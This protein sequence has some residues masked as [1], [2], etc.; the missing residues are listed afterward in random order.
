MVSDERMSTIYGV[1]A[2]PLPIFTPYR[3]GVWWDKVHEYVH[4]GVLD[5][6]TMSGP[7]FAVV[8]A[9]KYVAA[10]VTDHI[11][12]PRLSQVLDLYPM[13]PLVDRIPFTVLSLEVP[14]SHMER[15]I[16]P[17]SALGALCLRLWK[18]CSLGRMTDLHRYTHGIS[19]DSYQTHFLIGALLTRLPLTEETARVVQWF[20]CRA[21]LSRLPKTLQAAIF[22]T[23][24]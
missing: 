24:A 16:R 9:A 1:A 5:V 22:H 3:V 2:E 6:E 19:L 17:S 14:E 10:H 8:R 18:A 21:P 11:I 12:L 4:S 7:E 15:L 23:T 13:A 20:Q